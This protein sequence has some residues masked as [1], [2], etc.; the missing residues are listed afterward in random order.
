[1]AQRLVGTYDLLN[2][3]AFLNEPDPVTL[4][5]GPNGIV[6]DAMIK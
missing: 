6:T 2:C 3:Q 4:I 1:M 5:T